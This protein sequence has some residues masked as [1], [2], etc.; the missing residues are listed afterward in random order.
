MR[1]L[2]I[3]FP[4]LCVILTLTVFNYLLKVNIAYESDKII[5]YTDEIHG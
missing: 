5:D 1:T 4:K 2:Y 3:N